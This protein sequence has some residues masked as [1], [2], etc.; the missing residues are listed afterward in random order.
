VGLQFPEVTVDYI[1]PIQLSK[2][3]TANLSFESWHTL[4]IQ[5]VRYLR[6]QESFGEDLPQL[7]HLYMNGVIASQENTGVALLP[8]MENSGVFHGIIVEIR[9]LLSQQG[10]PVKYM[11]AVVE[12]NF[13]RMSALEH[14]GEEIPNLAD[15]AD[16]HKDRAVIVASQHE[17]ATLID[18]FIIQNRLGKQFLL[19]VPDGIYP[20]NLKA[21][22]LPLFDPNDVP[23]EPDA[24]YPRMVSDVL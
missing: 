3:N 5:R 22:I 12:L 14:Y 24:P 2:E 9:K 11:T 4:I 19:R 15:I 23:P 1:T 10:L 18:V 21:D 16:E 13:V 7:L 20:D 8:S 17:A 6:A